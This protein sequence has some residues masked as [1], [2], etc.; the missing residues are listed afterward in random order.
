MYDLGITIVQTN[1][2]EKE[3]LREIAGRIVT[4]QMYLDTIKILKSQGY[5]QQTIQ[6]IIGRV[7]HFRV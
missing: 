1:T 5:S 4:I 7:R 2:K 3:L 6:D